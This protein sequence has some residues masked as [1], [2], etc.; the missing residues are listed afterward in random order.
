[1]VAK[2]NK[3]E[4]KTEVKLYKCNKCGKEVVADDFNSYYSICFKCENKSGNSL[5]RAIVL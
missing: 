4:I 2:E 3:Q 5:M 1:M